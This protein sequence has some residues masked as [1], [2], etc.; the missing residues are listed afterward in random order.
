[1][2]WADDVTYS[3]HDTEDFYRAGLIPLD[4]LARNPKEQ[5]RFVANI[6]ERYRARGKPS[7]TRANSFGAVFGWLFGSL[8]IRERFEGG[9]DQQ[10]LLLKFV[11][12]KI[13]LY[14]GRTELLPPPGQDGESFDLADSR[15]E[16]GGRQPRLAG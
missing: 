6:D 11:A 10:R 4:R 3:V 15:R 1:M 2:D 7:P 16:T 5:G 9:R 13:E 8:E 14:V 12:D